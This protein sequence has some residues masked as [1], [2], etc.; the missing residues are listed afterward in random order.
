MITIVL[1]LEGN[2]HH[3]INNFIDIDNFIKNNYLFPNEHIIN[4]EYLNKQFYIIKKYIYNNLF[5]KEE[6]EMFKIIDNNNIEITSYTFEI[7]KEYYLDNKN[8]F[9]N[10]SYPCYSKINVSDKLKENVLFFN[11]SKLLNELNNSIYKNKEIEINLITLF[12]NTNDR[13]ISLNNRTFTN[14]ELFYKNNNEGELMMYNDLNFI[15]KNFNKINYYNINYNNTSTI[16]ICNILK[17]CLKTEYINNDTKFI[18][19]EYD[20][21]II[22]NNKNRLNIEKILNKFDEI[23]KFKINTNFETIN[24]IFYKNDNLSIVMC[25]TKLRLQ[26]IRMSLLSIYCQVYKINVNYNEIICNNNLLIKEEYLNNNNYYLFLEIVI[27]FDNYL[28]EEIEYLKKLL[29][30]MKINYKFI[31]IKNKNYIGSGLNYDLGIKE[32]N[33]DIIILQNSEVMHFGNIIDEIIDKSNINN[34]IISNTIN[35]NSLDENNNIYNDLNILTDYTNDNKHYW[36]THYKYNNRNLHYLISFNKKILKENLL[37][38]KDF[39]L[40]PYF[41]DDA[42]V[43]RISNFFNLTKINIVNDKIYSVHLYH[44]RDNNLNYYQNDY[45][46]NF[47]LILYY[48]KFYYHKFSNNYL[49]INNNYDKI[50]LNKIIIKCI[51]DLKFDINK[52]NTNNLIIEN[53]YTKKFYCSFDLFKKFK[54]LIILKPKIFDMYCITINDV[55]RI[56]HMKL[57]KEKIKYNFIFFNGVTPNSEQVIKYIK[58]NHVI[59]PLKGFV[60]SSNINNNLSVYQISCFISFL[61]LIIF[62]YNKIN[63]NEFIII[64]EDDIIFKNKYSNIVFNNL[65]NIIF[66]NININDVKTKGIIFKLCRQYS[67]VKYN[68]TDDNNFYQ[69]IDDYTTYS[70]ACFV[71]NKKYLEFVLLTY[72]EYKQIPT[73]S[74]SLIHYLTIEKFKKNIISKSILPIIIDQESLPEDINIKNNFKSY[75][76]PSLNEIISRFQSRLINN[77]N[78]LIINYSENNFLPKISDFFNEEFKLVNN[79]YFE[80]YGDNYFYEN[81]LNDV[82]I[83]NTQKYFAINNPNNIYIII[84]NLNEYLQIIQNFKNKYPEHELNNI[85]IQYKLINNLE[86]NLYLYKLCI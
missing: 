46:L 18:L 53:N 56:K 84:Y 47:N 59:N 24:K 13:L 19:K 69:V 37:F 6:K 25:Y 30:Q 64:C 15:K 42:L 60:R 26:Q 41:E 86:N 66:S 4:K 27:V 29:E 49:M 28:S 39:Y 8:L 79:I 33:N 34:Y 5:N 23:K 16:N 11:I 14:N 71:V 54:N 62:N 68:Y 1:G 20:N 81:K 38:D 67:P 82:I 12:R 43:L 31:I 78:N 32:T 70:N 44:N 57:F 36:N 7:D 21:Y 10:Y 55:E 3:M 45:N 75:V 65:E 76:R 63:D 72:K 48:L 74:D 85:N 77:F 58:N 2:G 17:K 50:L 61:N 9:I 80:L 73:T 51:Y 83:T 35:I 40:N 22:D 52:L